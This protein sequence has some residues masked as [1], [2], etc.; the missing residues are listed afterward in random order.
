MKIL[1]LPLPLPAPPSLHHLPLSHH[2]QYK[3]EPGYED[4]D[5][6]PRTPPPTPATTPPATTVL[7]TPNFASQQLLD[8]LHLPSFSAPSMGKVIEAKNYIR[9][10]HHETLR[11]SVTARLDGYLKIG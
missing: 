5:K 1:Y 6:P 2:F 7:T 9:K 3:N 10:I 11:I 4:Y 8:P